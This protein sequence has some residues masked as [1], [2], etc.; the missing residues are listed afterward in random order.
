MKLFY[1]NTPESKVLHVVDIIDG[2][3]HLHIF[4]HK[5]FT[6]L[7]MEKVAFAQCLSA[8]RAALQTPEVANQYTQWSPPRLVYADDLPNGLTGPFQYIGSNIF[9]PA[10]VGMFGAD[11]WTDYQVLEA[12]GGFDGSLITL[13]PWRSR[14]AMTKGIKTVSGTRWSRLVGNLPIAMAIMPFKTEA[15]ADI[16]IELRGA[17]APL[18][19]TEGVEVEQFTIA[20]EV[21]VPW[22]RFMWHVEMEDAEPIHAMNG[23]TAKFYLAWNGTNER[24]TRDIEVDVEADAGYLPM[25]KLRF[26]DGIA[27]LPIIPIG[28]ASGDKINVKMGVGPFTKI[29]GFQF[30]VE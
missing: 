26:T 10:N 14:L 13:G 3:L 24:I 20:P 27:Y 15:L 21:P 28:L 18:V 11:E 7:N 23:G 16:R 29:S 5:G 19:L 8:A 22:Q 9:N 25:R 12:M 6:P 2:A 1:L 30:E 17:F 4:Q